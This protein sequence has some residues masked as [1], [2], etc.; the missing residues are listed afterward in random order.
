MIKTY[1]NES[2][3]YHLFPNHPYSESNGSSHLDCDDRFLFIIVILGSKAYAL[4]L[5]TRTLAK[6][7]L[8][9]PFTMEVVLLLQKISSVLLGTAVFSFVNNQYGKWIF[10]RISGSPVV[11]ATEEILFM[12]GLIFIISQLFKRGVE[13]Q[14]ENDL[15]I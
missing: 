5:V 14:S 8:S 7:N 15:T 11:F 2:N 12:A 6:V 3:I 9:T 13:L 1:Q 10:K 4:W